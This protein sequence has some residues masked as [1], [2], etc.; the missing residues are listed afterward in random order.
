MIINEFTDLKL[1][2]KLVQRVADLGYIN[3]TP[4][5]SAV[6]PVMLT[7]CDVIGQAQTGTGKTAAFSLP[8]LHNI[9]KKQNYVQSLVVTPTRELAIQVADAIYKY[10]SNLNV[11]VLAVYGG[12]S[13]SRQINCLKKGVDIVVGTPGRLLDLVRQKALD[14]GRVSSVV[15]DEADEML[16]MGFI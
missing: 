1:H 14:L 16:S 12:Q 5:Q 15:L 9:L 11:R 7:G 4:I 10:G 13:Y 3:P 2:P 8:I 6:I